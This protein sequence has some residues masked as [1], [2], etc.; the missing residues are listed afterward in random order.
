MAVDRPQI[1][2]LSR[3]AGRA[4]HP[5]EPMPRLESAADRRREQH[6]NALGL[7]F[8]PRCDEAAGVFENLGRGRALLQAASFWRPLPMLAGQEPGQTIPLEGT[9]YRCCSTSAGARKRQGGGVGH[10][11]QFSLRRKL[12]A[13][14]SFS[15]CRR[16]KPTELSIVDPAGTWAWWLVLSAAVAVLWRPPAA[17]VAEVR[18]HAAVAEV[19]LHAAV[20]EVRL[21][22]AAAEEVPRHGAAA[23]EVWLHGVVA[24]KEWAVISAGSVDGQPRSATAS[25]PLSSSRHRQWGCL[26]ARGCREQ[27]YRRERLPC[28]SEWWPHCQDRPSRREWSPPD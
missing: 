18:L 12:G 6:W 17:A 28:R 8:I 26:C 9:L 22:A 2:G 23:E 25:V 14:W 24:A 3:V 16:R 11:T 5:K 4:A 19:R 21:H 7:P 1:D 20:A 27:L 13:L 10:P 15:P